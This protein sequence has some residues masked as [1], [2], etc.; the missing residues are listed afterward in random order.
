MAHPLHWQWC[1]PKP[2]I[3]D[4]ED[5]TGPSADSAERRVSV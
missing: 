1:T 5:R 2:G 3:H 4:V